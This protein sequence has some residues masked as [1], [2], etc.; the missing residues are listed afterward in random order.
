MAEYSAGVLFYYKQNGN[1]YFLLGKDRRGKWSDFGGKCESC[2]KS[3]IDTASREFYEETIGIVLNRYTISHILNTC[4]Y[5]EGRSYLNK[6]YYMF[7]VE[8]NYRLRYSE[9]FK[10][11]YR[12][13]KSILGNNSHFCEKIDVQWILKD[14]IQK[15]TKNEIRQV[16]YSTFVNNLT[17]ILNIVHSA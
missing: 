2:D 3:I 8:M 5:V 4:S 15:N 1:V 13:I 17:E 9:Q 14:N 11:S 6:P 12:F 16:F 10:E 7:I